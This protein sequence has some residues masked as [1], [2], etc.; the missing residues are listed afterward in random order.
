[1][2]RWREVEGI[3]GGRLGS[4]VDSGGQEDQGVLRGTEQRRG[5]VFAKLCIAHVFGRYSSSSVIVYLAPASLYP[6]TCSR[7]FRRI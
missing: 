3:A 6:P 4:N 7:F 1:M 5:N 2:A